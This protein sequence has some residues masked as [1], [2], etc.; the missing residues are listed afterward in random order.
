M[1]GYIYDNLDSNL[2]NAASLYSIR[3]LLQPPPRINN[4][5]CSVFLVKKWYSIKKAVNRNMG[6]IR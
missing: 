6:T 5:I 1:R 3:A 2:D 4:E